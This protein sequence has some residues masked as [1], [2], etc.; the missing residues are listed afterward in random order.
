MII[1]PK[2]KSTFHVT[3]GNYKKPLTTTK[4]E[5]RKGKFIDHVFKKC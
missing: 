4:I 5:I 1:A 3:R 2:Y